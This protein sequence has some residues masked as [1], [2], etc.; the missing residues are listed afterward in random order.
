[1]DAALDNAVEQR[2]QKDRETLRRWA[3]VVL[4]W[5]LI[6]AA[7]WYFFNS[8]MSQSGLESG[9]AAPTLVVELTDGTT[10]DLAEHRGQTV[11]INFWAVWCP[12]CRAEAPALTR[13]ARHLEAEGGHLIGLAVDSRSVP[14]AARLGMDY[15]IALATGEDQ[16]RF[17]VQML[18]TTIVVGPD[19]Q[20][21]RSFVGEVTEAQL[22]EALP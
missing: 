4:P 12:P 16:A 1:M 18:P 11:V 2:D 9:E 8:G 17:G 15:P 7:F 6:S 10:F 20:V 13:V 19:G 14:R 5:V 22:L 21:A 3:R